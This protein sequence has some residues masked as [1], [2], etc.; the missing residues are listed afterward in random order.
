MNIEIEAMVICKTL[1][2]QN[3]FIT[4]HIYHTSWFV[5]QNSRQINLKVKLF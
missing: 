2:F 5:S 1:Y 4:C 3:Q